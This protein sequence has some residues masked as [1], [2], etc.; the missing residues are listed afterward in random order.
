MNEEKKIEVEVEIKKN[1]DKVWEFW[2]KPEH[3]TKWNFASEDWLCPSAENDL[4]EG[5]KFVYRMEAKDG[6]FSFDFSGIYEEIKPKEKLVY[7]LD[8][9][10]MA[11]IHFSEDDETTKVKEIFEAEENNSKEMQKD[12]WQAILN[13]FKKYAESEK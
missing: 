3:I 8:D 1:L 11:N 12:G 7:K 13:N 2:T 5:G 6:S 10:R 4:K 9:G